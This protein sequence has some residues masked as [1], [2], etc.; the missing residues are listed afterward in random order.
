MLKWERLQLMITNYPAK[1]DGTAFKLLNSCAG[2]N[3]VTWGYLGL[4][5]LTR[6]KF[7]KLQM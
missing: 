7:I 4:D 1:D 2:L 3:I 6:S 5:P